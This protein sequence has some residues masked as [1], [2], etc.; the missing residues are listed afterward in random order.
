MLYDFSTIIALATCT[1][2]GFVCA[3][4]NLKIH[5]R[6]IF[7]LSRSFLK[8]K[9]LNLT[10]KKGKRDGEPTGRSDCIDSEGV[11]LP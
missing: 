5:F 4:S 3:Q 7:Q 11:S 9:N 2:F 8:L 6:I 1:C 10:L